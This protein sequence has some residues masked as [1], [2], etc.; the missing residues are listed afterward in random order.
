[1]TIRKQLEEIVAEI[2]EKEKRYNESVEEISERAYNVIYN[3]FRYLLVDEKAVQQL[4]YEDLRP[5]FD[6]VEKR[7]SEQR[8]TDKETVDQDLPEEHQ[9]NPVFDMS[10]YTTD[11]SAVTHAKE[12]QTLKHHISELIDGTKFERQAKM[13]RERDELIVQLQ[14]RATDKASVEQAANR[15]DPEIVR[16]RAYLMRLQNDEYIPV[17]ECRNPAKDMAYLLEKLDR[18]TEKSSVE[19]TEIDKV[20][21]QCLMCTAINNVL[22]TPDTPS[23]SQE[24][25]R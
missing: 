8:L 5:F 9:G 14:E 24:K 3:S 21:C 20:G 12:I 1:M 17:K 15:I 22:R 19:Q 7:I 11:E 23:V 13:L 16:I 25:K 18:P 2:E 4:T 6:K 10:C